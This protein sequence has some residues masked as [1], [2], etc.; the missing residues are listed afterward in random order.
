MNKYTD[1]GIEAIIDRNTGSMS[2]SNKAS[3]TLHLIVEYFNKVYNTNV[4]L[5]D[6]GYIRGIENERKGV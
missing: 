4:C 1:I 3:D 2:R 5:K 6:I